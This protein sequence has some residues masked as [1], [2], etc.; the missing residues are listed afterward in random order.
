MGH[1]YPSLK[2]TVEI[3][4]DENRIFIGGDPEGLRSLANL[5]NYLADVNQSEI[6]FMPNG[7]RDHT[8]LNPGGELS[9][10]SEAT[11]ICRLDAKGTGEFPK[12][13]K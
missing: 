9:E 10:Y 5:I 7:E 8:H 1:T 12:R 13:Y 11:E 6:P 4:H 3:S 2:G